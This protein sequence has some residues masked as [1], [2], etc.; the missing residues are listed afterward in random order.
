MHEEVTRAVSILRSR[1]EELQVTA[2]NLI[3]F[4]AV[5]TRPVANNGLGLPIAQAEAEITSLREI[6]AL[7]PDI[8]EILTE[9]EEIV[10][11]YR[12]IGKQAH[13]A[14]LVAAMLVHGVTHILTFN[15]DD[16]KRYHE[17]TVVNPQAIS[18]E[19]TK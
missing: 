2:Q 9:W 7:L 4:W 12:V 17:I 5:C 8:P 11:R 10:S 16:F 1:Q 15:T 14:H 6:F 19:D 18:E 13:D 3:E